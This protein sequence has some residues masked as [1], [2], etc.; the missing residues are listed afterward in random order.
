MGMMLTNNGMLT[1]LV[2]QVVFVKGKNGEAIVRSKPV[3]KKKKLTSKRQQSCDRFTLGGDFIKPMYPFLKDSFTNFLGKR[4]ARDAVRSY[5]LTQGVK[6]E[7]GVPVIAYEKVLISTGNIRSYQALNQQLVTNGLY[8][9][10]DADTHQAF[11][12]PDDVLS[13]VVYVP[14]LEAYLFFKACALRE[15]GAITLELPAECSQAGFHAW[16]T[17]ANATQDEYA[18]STYLGSFE[19]V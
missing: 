12:Q 13:V 14:V 5:A 1:G 8:L 15:S 3:Y 9:Q 17:F 11:A 16:A 7:Q 4:N 18:F 2:G 19:A 6:L 10:W